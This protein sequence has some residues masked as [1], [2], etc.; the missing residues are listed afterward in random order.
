MRKTPS[1][2]DSIEQRIERSATLLKSDWSL[3]VCGA[4]VIAMIAYT[5]ISHAGRGMSRPGVP[6]AVRGAAQ[7][8]VRPAAVNAPVW[9]TLYSCRTHGPCR[10][11]FDA[12]ALPRCPVCNQTMMVNP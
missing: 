5:M 7:V 3:A 2:H 10:A 12:G 1:G 11:V 8:P 9:K 6:P 4:A